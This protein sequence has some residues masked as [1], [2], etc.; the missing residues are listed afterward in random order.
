MRAPRRHHGGRASARGGTIVG[1]GIAS[2]HPWRRGRDLDHAGALSA[3]RAQDK[4]ADFSPAS[5]AM[6]KGLSLA[7]GHRPAVRLAAQDLHPSG[8]AGDAT[9][10]SA[11]KASACSITA[12]ARSA[13]CS[14]MSINLI[15]R[16]FRAGPT[17]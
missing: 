12:P 3:A 8:A 9:L 6:E 4:I 17:G 1:G 13:N 14:P 10:A 11:E 2:R 16:R 15:R 7:F 5:I